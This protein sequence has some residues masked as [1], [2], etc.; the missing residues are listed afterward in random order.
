VANLA[1]EVIQGFVGGLVAGLV[2]Y[3]TDI[4]T[5]AIF[6]AF[7][8]LNPLIP[9]L[10]FVFAVISFFT[11]MQEAYVT[12]FFFSLGIVTAGFLLRDFVTIVAG[13]ISI[14]GLVLSFFKR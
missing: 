13:F 10:G 3:V 8:A 14:A 2:G 5:G 6:E 7:K 12:G 11:G 1:L 4:A 9:L